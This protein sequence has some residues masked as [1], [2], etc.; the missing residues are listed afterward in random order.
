M[1]CHLTPPPPHPPT[2]PPPHGPLFHSPPPPAFPLSILP[3]PAC[4]GVPAARADWGPGRAADRS[5]PAAYWGSGRRG[6]PPHSKGRLDACLRPTCGISPHAV[7][8]THGRCDARRYR[9]YT[10]RRLP[11]GDTR[12]MARRN[13]YC[14]D[15]RSYRSQT[16]VRPICGRW[17]ARRTGPPTRTL[18]GGREGRAIHGL[19][20]LLWVGGWAGGGS[21]GGQ[22]L[23]KG[24]AQYSWHWV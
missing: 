2:P 5:G 14:T 18:G 13:C 17:P 4:A 22:V 1:P 3:R 8:A 15:P 23:L 20:C 16:L 11:A 21:G 7:S 6:L 24:G 10:P 19:P 12:K 9:R